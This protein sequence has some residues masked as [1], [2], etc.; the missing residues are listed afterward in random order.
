MPDTLLDVVRRYAE[1]H[2]DRAG[3]ART[4][5]PGLGT[6]RATSPSGLMHAVSR[7]LVCLVLQGGKQVAMGA[8]LFAFAAGRFQVERAERGVE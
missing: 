6:V 4:P 8:Q 5:I 7:P 2:A 3:F 1:A